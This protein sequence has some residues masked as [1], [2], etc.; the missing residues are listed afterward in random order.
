MDLYIF[1]LGNNKKRVIGLQFMAYEET[2]FLKS[3]VY[4]GPFARTGMP[5]CSLCL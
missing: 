3:D 5:G 4:F 2:M 1:D